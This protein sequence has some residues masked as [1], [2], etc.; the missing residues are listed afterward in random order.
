VTTRGLWLLAAAAPVAAGFALGTY[1]SAQ[2]C[3]VADPWQAI[4]VAFYA[5]LAAIVVAA[6]AAWRSLRARGRVV[7]GLGAA[8]GGVVLYGCVVAP[9]AFYVVIAA[10]A[11]LAC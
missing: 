2:E 6:I 9:L 11:E 8:F 4:A 7:A 1:T 5:W 10:F 3:D